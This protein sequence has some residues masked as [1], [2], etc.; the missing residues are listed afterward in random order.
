MFSCI[1]LCNPMDS[2]PPR[3]SVHGILQARTLEWSAISF[4]RGFSWP[5]DWTQVSCIAGRFFTIWAT[6]KSNSYVTSISDRPKANKSILKE[7]TPEYWLEGLRLKLKFQYFGYLMWRPDSFEKT[8]M[9]EKI[10][11]GR[12]GRQRMRWMDG[13]TN[14]LDMSLSKLCKLV[15][16]REAWR[17][18]VHGG[19]K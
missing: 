1:W 4:S 14:S 13:I 10:E 16:D 11:G 3:S 8:L 17:A 19:H 12:R 18:A 9:L 6:R 7:I 15:M 2:S 5:R